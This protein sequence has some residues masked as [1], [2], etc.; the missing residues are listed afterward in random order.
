MERRFD[1]TKG[2]RLIDCS[3]HCPAFEEGEKYPQWKYDGGPLG[4]HV[5][6]S[7][8]PGRSMDKAPV[9]VD[10]EAPDQ[11]KTNPKNDILGRIISSRRIRRCCIYWSEKLGYTVKSNFIN[12]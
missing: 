10:P 7:E 8:D 5:G 4:V 6:S 9:C 2:P 3:I 12:E 1:L 11:F